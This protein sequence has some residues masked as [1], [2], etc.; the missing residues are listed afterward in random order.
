MSV[1]PSEEEEKYFARTEADKRKALRH[2]LGKAAE[3][4]QESRKIAE[5]IG[6]G[7]EELVGRLRSLGFDG[8]T[9]QVFDLLPLIH[10]AWADG[11]IERNERGLIFKVLEQRGVAKGSESWELIGA[12]LDEEPSAAFMDETLALLRD[13]AASKPGVQSS[14][15]DL[16]LMVADASGGILGFGNKVSDEEKE[17]IRHIAE[18]LG[19]DAQSKFAGRFGG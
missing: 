1:K 5:K 7:N 6:T 12:L 15:L 13:L 14:V 19:P 4:L 3:E 8:E 9:A 11:K 16:C 2:D 17:L 10:V 18:T